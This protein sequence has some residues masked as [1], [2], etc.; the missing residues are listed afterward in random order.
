MG[1]VLIWLGRF[2]RI[3]FLLGT[4]LRLRL[5]N[6]RIEVGR[7]CSIHKQRCCAGIGICRRDHIDRV[8]LLVVGADQHFVPAANDAIPVRVTGHDVKCPIR[9]VHLGHAR[10][11]IGPFR[12]LVL[13]EV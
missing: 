11:G 12:Q 9:Y 2:A 10:T 13:S 5:S 8:V 1:K 3:E 7:F 6:R 4:G